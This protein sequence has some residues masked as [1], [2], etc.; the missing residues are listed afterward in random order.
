MAGRKKENE[1]LVFEIV[2]EIGVLSEGKNGWSKQVNIV[3]WG[4][5]ESKLD[6]RSWNE[7]RSK[8]S[9]GITLDYEETQILKNILNEKE[10][11]LDF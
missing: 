6:I 5:S 10:D 9:K 2:R 1:E 8:M 11:E 3:K 4:D 7:D